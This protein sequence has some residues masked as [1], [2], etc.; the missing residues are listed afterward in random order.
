MKKEKKG[1]QFA[2]NTLVTK[3]NII[4]G[5]CFEVQT[6]AIGKQHRAEPKGEQGAGEGD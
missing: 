2:Q 6:T 3:K 4:G 1:R 5:Y